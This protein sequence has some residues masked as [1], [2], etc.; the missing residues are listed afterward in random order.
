VSN[1]ARD[2]KIATGIQW[3]CYLTGVQTC[4]DGASITE[5]ITPF[6]GELE[7]IAMFLTTLYLGTYSQLKSFYFFCFTKSSLLCT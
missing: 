4:L 3:L 1:I 2:K 7:N 5:T 6:F